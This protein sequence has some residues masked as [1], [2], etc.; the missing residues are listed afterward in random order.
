MLRL[1]IF[2]SLFAAIASGAWATFRDPTP[3][4]AAAIL[5]PTPDQIADAQSWVTPFFDWMTGLTP[6]SLSRLIHDAIAD[7]KA[8]LG[9]EPIIPPP[10]SGAAASSEGPQR[11]RVQHAPAPSPASRTGTATGS[12]TPAQQPGIDWYRDSK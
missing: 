3:E 12:Q 7:V 5:N 9:D 2:F 4:N 10:P 11:T 1:A 8:S 6:D